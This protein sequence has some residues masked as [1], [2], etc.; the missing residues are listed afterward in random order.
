MAKVIDFLSR[1]EAAA[2]EPGPLLEGF[3]IEVMPRT[4]A[5]IDSFAAILPAGTRVYVAHIDGT[6]IS[7]MVATAARLAREGFEVMPHFPARSI[8]GRAALADWIA[9]YQGEAGVDQALLLGGGV[10]KPRG[11]FHSSMQLMETGLF[12]RAGFRRLHV[13]G[14]PEGAPDIPG[15]EAALMAALRWK[16][17]FAELSDIEM[18]IVTQFVFEA[19]PV[20]DWAARLRAE[21]ITLP[22]HVGVAGPAKLQTLIRYAL[23]CGVGPSVRVLQKRAADVT[24]LMRPFAPDEVLADLAAARAADPAFQLEGAHIFP[25]GGVA[26]A[27]EYAAGSAAAARSFAT[28]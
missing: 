4:A 5:K 20:I 13:A 27:A 28:A 22:I 6:P 1:R 23:A 25:L 17:E 7:E 18:A 21:G 12:D 15:G 8:P 26:K 16:Q 10:A 24:R 19:R 11:E 3:S 2:T 9:R 14:H